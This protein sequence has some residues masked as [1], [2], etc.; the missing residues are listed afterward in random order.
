MNWKLEPFHLRTPPPDV[1]HTVP[2][3]SSM[4]LPPE[5]PLCS[6]QPVP[7]YSARPLNAPC[8]AQML[9]EGP[10]CTVLIRLNVPHGSSS[11]KSNCCQTPVAG[12]KE[13]I[14]GRMLTNPFTIQ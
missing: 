10:A 3:R 2:A 5:P 8:V 12:S 7:S 9:P 11:P 6:V 4:M 1:S 14:A 13:K